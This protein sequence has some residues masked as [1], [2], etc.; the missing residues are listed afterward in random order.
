ML[1]LVERRRPYVGDE[2][3]LQLSTRPYPIPLIADVEVAFLPAKAALKL[4]AS[5][6][7]KA[8][9]PVNVEHYGS[10]AHRQREGGLAAAVDQPVPGVQRR[11]EEAS[12]APLE[13]LLASLFVP[14]LG[15]APA[16]HDI[17]QLLVEVPFG[18]QGPSG[19][20]LNHV[21]ARDPFLALELDIGAGAA[22]AGP[23]LAGQIVQ[24][25]YP[26]GLNDGDALLLHP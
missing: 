16:F 12:L 19:G 26:V 3:G 2:V 4:V 22:H 10:G 15:E 11:C 1:R 18:V 14:D 13:G 7:D 23:G 24:V 9:I 5:I 25:L 20:D 8:G 21:H 6:E 17:D